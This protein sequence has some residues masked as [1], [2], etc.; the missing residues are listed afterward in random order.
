MKTHFLLAFLVAAA[1]PPIARGG[2][3][4]AA[5]I[6]QLT[7]KAHGDFVDL[8]TDSKLIV[9]EP[10]QAAGREYQFLTISR[11]NEKRLVRFLAPG[12]VKGM[13]MLIE[14]RDTMYAFLPG[15]QRVR[16]LG[17]HVKN[18]SFMGSDA[19]FEDMAEGAFT[20]FYE[21]R[22]VGTEGNEWILELTLLPGKEAEFPKRKVWIDKTIHQIT[23]LEDYDAKGGNV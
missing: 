23:R 18:Q 15:F 11:G 8:T 22:L 5:E 17:T 20:G 9:R 3:P 12:D 19:S 2:E 16:R 13:G 10:G 4:T 21:P 14:N 6:L 7:D 1:A